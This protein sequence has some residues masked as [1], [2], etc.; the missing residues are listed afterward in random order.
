MQVYKNLTIIGTSH[1]APESMKEVKETIV[2]RKPGL[3]ALELDGGRFIAMHQKRKQKISIA[4]IRGLG[5]RGFL[6]NVFGAWVE[7]KLGRMVG[8]KPGSEMMAA[9]RLAK[10]LDIH[11]A[12]IDRDIRITIKRLLKAI[13]WKERWH[14]IADIFKGIFT[15]KKQLQMF[16][17]RKVPPEKLIEQLLQKTKERYPS[18]YRVLVTER[19]SY[20]AKALNKLL[21][22]YPNIEIIAVVG[23]G[24]EKS[25]INRIRRMQHGV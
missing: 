15:A 13:T 25:I 16:D 10:E 22:D 23:A 1:I 6:F 20:M 17:L 2:S 8:V 9:A 14:F 5:I 24:H 21:I 4:M 12:L 11:I 7:T 3:I 19:D 18:F